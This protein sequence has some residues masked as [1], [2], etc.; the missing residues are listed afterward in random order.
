MVEVC[1]KRPRKTHMLC[2]GCN[3]DHRYTYFPHRKDRVRDVHNVNQE[4]TMEDMGNRVP[5]IYA[6]LDNNKVEF[7]SHMIEVEGMINNHS[8]IILMDPRA[9]YSYIDPRVV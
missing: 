2:W 4:E 9:S 5:R 6:T 1:W 8:F 7:Q 3:G